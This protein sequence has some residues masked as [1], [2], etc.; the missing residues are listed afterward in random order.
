M[1]F[2]TKPHRY[3]IGIAPTS[4]ARCRS[5]RRVIEKGALRLAIHAFVRPNRGTT[6]TRHLTPKCI[7]T[8][9]AADVVRAHGVPCGVRVDGGL[10]A[11]AVGSAWKALEAQAA[12]RVNGCSWRRRCTKLKDEVRSPHQPVVGT[13]LRY[14]G[15]VEVCGGEQKEDA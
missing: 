4:R 3:T 15:R 7:D 9:L 13:M 2:K 14:L 8:A 6:F 5:C 11:G 10:E 12:E 1:T